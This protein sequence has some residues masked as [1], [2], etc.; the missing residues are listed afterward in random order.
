MRIF[1]AYPAL[2]R[3]QLDYPRNIAGPAALIGGHASSPVFFEA[4][5]RPPSLPP[6]R[7]PFLTPR[8][9]RG[10][11]TER[12]TSLQSCRTPNGECGRLPALHRGFSVPGTVTSG[13]ATEDFTGIRPL[14]LT[15]F[16]PLASAPRPAIQGR[17]SSWGRTV[18]RGLPSAGLRALPAGAASGPIFETS[19]EDAPRGPDGARI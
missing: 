15:G 11:S 13:R 2:R 12:R 14:A 3:P 17:P 16:R 7:G 10:W 9:S 4:P 1:R 19:R 5:G 8:K 18:T 6:I